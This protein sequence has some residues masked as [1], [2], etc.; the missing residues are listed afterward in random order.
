MFSSCLCNAI[1]A[2][3]VR[4]GDIGADVNSVHYTVVVVAG[5]E[6]WSDSVPLCRV[7]G[8]ITR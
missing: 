7:C 1:I 2:G 6:S 8:S 4:S 5:S 3:E